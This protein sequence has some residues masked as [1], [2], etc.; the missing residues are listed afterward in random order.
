MITYISALTFSMG[1]E[2]GPLVVVGI[3]VG[4]GLLLTLIL[5]PISFSPIEYYE[6]INPNGIK[7]I[8]TLVC[9]HVK[10]MRTVGEMYNILY[11]KCK[12]FISSFCSIISYYTRHKSNSN[13]HSDCIMYSYD[14]YL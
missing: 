4:L 3:I 5:V 2:R 14:L 1:A 10:S 12:L 7:R 8:S 9:L 11:C 13:F 6:V